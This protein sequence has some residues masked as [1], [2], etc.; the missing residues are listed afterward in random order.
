MTPTMTPTATPAATLTTTPTATATPRPRAHSPPTRIRI[1]RIDVD[2]DVVE[3]GLTTKEENG[4]IVTVWEVAKFAAGFHRGSAYPGH[5]GNTVIS[6]H[7]QS[8][9]SG[10]VFLHL[11][12]LS[13]GDDVYLY[14]DEREFHYL[15]TQRML[16]KEKGVSEEVRRKNAKWIQPTDDERLTLVSCWPPVKPDHRVIII[17]RPQWD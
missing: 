14:A 8:R 1:P 15:V 12:D 4:E 5:S 17:A 9:Q 3:V 16:L 6:G 2:A 11:M 10:D 13:P 7:V